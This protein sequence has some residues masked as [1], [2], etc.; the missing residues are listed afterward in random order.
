[1]VVI[2]LY[3]VVIFG[4]LSRNAITSVCITLPV[5]ETL[6]NNNLVVQN[7]KVMS[8]MRK[9]IVQHIVLFH[10]HYFIYLQK[11]TFYQNIMNNDNWTFIKMHLPV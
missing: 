3:L 1:M 5:A 4:F 11:Y 9:T 10:T 6:L 8:H 7:L 2:D